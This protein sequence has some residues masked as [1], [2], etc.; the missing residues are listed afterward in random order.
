MFEYELWASTEVNNKRQQI[1]THMH[2]RTNTMRMGKQKKNTTPNKSRL[3]VHVGHSMP[4][5]Y[6]IE[7]DSFVGTGAAHRPTVRILWVHAVELVCHVPARRSGV[8]ADVRISDSA[9]I[10]PPTT[11]DISPHWQ[12]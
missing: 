4:E 12:R 1:Y 7:W 3:P 6:P 10:P 5:I 2:T 8:F 11:I 9:S